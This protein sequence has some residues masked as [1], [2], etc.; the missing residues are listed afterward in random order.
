MV[1]VLLTPVKLLNFIYAL[2]HP[3]YPLKFCIW[4]FFRGILVR[5]ST[6]EEYNVDKNYKS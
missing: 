1:F 4:V 6:F 5:F 3:I 2:E